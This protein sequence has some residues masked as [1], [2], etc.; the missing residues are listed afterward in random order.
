MEIARQLRLRDVGG[1]VIVD[2]IDMEKEISREKLET[3]LK[4][5]LARDPAAGH[6]SWA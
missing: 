6:P 4:E 1:M 2:F 3:C 5:A